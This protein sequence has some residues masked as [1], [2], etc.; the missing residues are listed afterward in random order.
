MT[1]I[2]KE[3]LSDG[4]ITSS[5]FI[6]EYLTYNTDQSYDSRRRMRLL[7]R[8]HWYIMFLDYDNLKQIFNE[9]RKNKEKVS[10]YLNH[11]WASY[12]GNT[13]A[14]TAAIWCKDPQIFSFLKFHGANLFI[15]NSN[16]KSVID[17]CLE[18]RE[19]YIPLLRFSSKRNPDDHIISSIEISELAITTDDKK[20]D[21]FNLLFSN[22]LLTT[23]I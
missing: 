7:L 11:K 9:I 8:I 15:L 2:I 13:A 20:L 5:I 18:E 3:K 17:L 22:N 23:P 10:K 14:H 4:G 19:Y 1:E 21:D 12:D 16:R 6:E